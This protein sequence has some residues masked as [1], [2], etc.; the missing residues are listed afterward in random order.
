[1]EIYDGNIC[2]NPQLCD[3]RFLDF[4]SDNLMTWKIIDAWIENFQGGHEAM[5]TCIGEGMLIAN[6]QILH[7]ID[8]WGEFYI[9]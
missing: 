3:V 1:M 6:F 4:G 5:N 2:W 9:V 8:E 7:Y